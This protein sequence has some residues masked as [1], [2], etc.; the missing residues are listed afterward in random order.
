[1]PLFFLFA[2]DSHQTIDVSCNHE[3]A[4]SVC[5]REFHDPDIDQVHNTAARNYGV[6]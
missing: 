4:T 1:M 6:V 5:N 2:Q 3:H